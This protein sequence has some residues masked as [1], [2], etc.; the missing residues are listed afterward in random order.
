M[1]MFIIVTMLKSTFL[2]SF[3]Q[4]FTCIFIL[5][6]AYAQEYADKDYYLVDSLVLEDLG[7][8]N[9]V[10]LEKYLDI[11]HTSSIDTVR[12]RA[13]FHLTFE[14]NHESRHKYNEVQF[15]IANKK[16]KQTLSKSTENFYSRILSAAISNQGYL[17]EENGMIDASIGKFK[18]SILISYEIS[19]DLGVSTGLN[20]LGYYFSSKGDMKTAIAYHKHAL[21]LRRK[22]N[23]PDRI[24]TSL[25]NLGFCYN[26]IGDTKT[27]LTY[28]FESLTI[29]DSIGDLSS[30]ARLFNNIGTICKT[31]KDFDKALGYYKQ[32]LHIYD[33]LDSDYGRALVYSNMGEVY[34]SL[35]QNRDAKSYYDKSLKLYQQLDNIKGIIQLKRALS[36][37]KIELLEFED[38]SKLLTEALEKAIDIDY[39]I[40]VAGVENSLSKYW[41]AKDSSSV[42]FY[43]VRRSL[44]IAKDINHLKLE[45]NAQLQLSECYK[46]SG[47]YEKGWAAYENYVIL[48]DSLSNPRNVDEILSKEAEF[49][50]QLGYDDY[51]TDSKD[52]IEKLADKKEDQSFLTFFVS[53]GTFVFLVLILWLLWIKKT[54]N[55][56]HRLALEKQVKELGKLRSEVSINLTPSDGKENSV[57]ELKDI[58]RFMAEPLTQSELNV[59]A[60]LIKGSSNKEIANT[61]FVSINTV[62][63]HLIKIYNKLKVN[64]R[65]QA[66]QKV[67]ELARREGRGK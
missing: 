52:T 56:A 43:H 34:N 1:K 24:A 30:K 59:L 29:S 35:E 7:E 58:N 25:N 48:K 28:Y 39:K 8:E 45:R 67:N 26:S 2:R 49:L 64:N 11:Y 6:G 33:E 10:V 15:G 51:E 36:D 4:I 16:L 20:N 13:L 47:D 54:S 38:A 18:E 63:S 66:T 9:R 22:L 60:E 46:R 17:L 42:A 44:K 19:D 32:G 55:N 14:L 31:Q 65:T 57:P 62:K 50:A 3:S 27:A 53:A 40:G 37:I 23:M 5:Q 21:E 12:C 41:L 61:L